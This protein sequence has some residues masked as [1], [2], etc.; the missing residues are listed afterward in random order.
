VVE[1]S[2]DAAVG[3]DGA[4]YVVWVDIADR[5]WVRAS[6]DGGVSWEDGVRVNGEGEIPGVSMARRPY[7]V[8]DETRV[9]VSFVDLESGLVHV[10]DSPSSPL[11]FDRAAV[12]GPDATFNDFAKPVFVEGDL[13]V[14]WQTYTPDGWIALAR[15]STGWETEPVEGVPG[16]PCE[17][18]PLD[19]R[20]VGSGELLVAFRNNDY[21][22]REHWVAILPGGDVAQASDTEGRVRTCPMEGPRLGEGLGAPLL[23]WADASGDGRTWVASSADDGRTWSQERDVFG[24]TDTSSPTLTTGGSGLVYATTEVD[25]A[26]FYA[27]SADGGVSFE[28][29]GELVGP[30]GRLGYAQLESAARVTVAAGTGADGSA[31]MYRVE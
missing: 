21:N 14:V 18:C 12:L 11:S 26:S 1:R 28:D 8:A 5:A 17:C 13:S 3:A 30:S 19:A 4:V 23:I 29:G 6:R 10:Y 15:E 22:L 31:W 24:A 27:V 16:L 25:D 2:V 7:V 20:V 9:A